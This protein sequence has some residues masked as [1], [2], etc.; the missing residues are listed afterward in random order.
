LAPSIQERKKGIA[1]A[2]MAAVAIPMSR[3]MTTGDTAVMMSRTQD[4]A[5]EARD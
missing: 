5:E 4:T 2:V 3:M 1:L